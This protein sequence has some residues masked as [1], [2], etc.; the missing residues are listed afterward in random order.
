MVMPFSIPFFAITAASFGLFTLVYAIVGAAIIYHLH[1]HSV[2]GRLAPRVVTV[3]FL[4]VSIALWLVA[5][6]F[7]FRLP[8]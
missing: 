7:L 6:L 4:V 5:L 1:V 2:A 8:R 3:V